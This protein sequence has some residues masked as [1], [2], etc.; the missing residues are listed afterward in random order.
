M[1]LR[2][3]KKGAPGLKIVPGISGKEAHARAP[4][5]LRARGAKKTTWQERSPGGNHIC[6][7]KNAEKKKK[8]GSLENSGYG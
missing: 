5:D 1:L 4:C 2:S 3:L 7:L 8:R 6:V